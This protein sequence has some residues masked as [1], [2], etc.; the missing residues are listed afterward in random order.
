MDSG[1]D[2]AEKIV[3]PAEAIEKEMKSYRDLGKEEKSRGGAVER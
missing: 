1:L 3:K 2:Y